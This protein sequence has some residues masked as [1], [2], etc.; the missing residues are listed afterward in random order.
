MHDDGVSRLGAIGCKLN[1]SERLSEGPAVMI[2]TRYGYVILNRRD[3]RILQ[4]DGKEKKEPFLIL[5]NFF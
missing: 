1:G 3:Q 4:D 5:H 2:V